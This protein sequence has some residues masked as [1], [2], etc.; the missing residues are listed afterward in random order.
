MAGEK[1]KTLFLQMA[2]AIP[3]PAA[4]G[5]AVLLAIYP[6]GPGMGPHA[7]TLKKTTAERRRD[8]WLRRG[9]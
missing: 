7:T 1:E 4:T 8:M 6:P 9:R 2:P 5:D 3:K